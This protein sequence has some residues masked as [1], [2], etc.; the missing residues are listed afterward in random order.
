LLQG[1]L[2]LGTARGGVAGLPAATVVPGR[3]YD[4]LAGGVVA[5]AEVDL[6][7]VRPF[8]GLIFGS[9]D[10]DP[11][12]DE[13]H[14]FA[15]LPTREITAIT[16][17]SLFA[18]LDP[19][20]AIGLRDYTCPARMQGVRSAAPAANPTAVGTA[21][22]GGTAGG[23][24]TECGHTVGNPF[25]D[26]MGNF[27]HLGIGT[28]YSN[29]GTL[30]IPVGLKAFPI[31]GHE[32]VGWYIYRGMVNTNLLE[33]AFRPEIQAGRISGISKTEYHE[34]G[35]F[36]QWTLNPHFDIRL[37]GNVAIPGAGYKDLARLAT[38]GAGACEGDDLALSAQ[39]RFRAR[40]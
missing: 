10:G 24:F 26:R 18:H 11:T 7:I 28:T 3:D 13:L 15:P 29:P 14:G 22:L 6:G 23:G 35:G 4:I 20:Q 37:A 17:T 19:S 30:L 21:V 34:L 12:D 9:A 8:V 2:V 32:L 36:W 27:S 25:N 38:C 16:G 1:N 40:F 33:T 39:A 5:Y 31:K